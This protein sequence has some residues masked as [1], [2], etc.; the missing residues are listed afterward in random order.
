MSSYWYEGIWGLCDS[1]FDEDVSTCIL[2]NSYQMHSLNP[3]SLLNCHDVVYY[4][5][6][7]MMKR[8]ICHCMF[9]WCYWHVL[10]SWYVVFLNIWLVKHLIWL[11]YNNDAIY[12]DHV[13]VL[14]NDIAFQHPVLVPVLRSFAEFAQVLGAAMFMINIGGW[15]VKRGW[16]QK[17]LS[18]K[19]REI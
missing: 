17:S 7:Q 16:R 6:C 9:T 18:G 5:Y 11:P 15:F 2:T 1:W 19:R 12:C 4:T 8:V 3:T 13:L 14:S 10:S